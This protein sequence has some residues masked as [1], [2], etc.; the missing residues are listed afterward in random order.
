MY[1]CTFCIKWENFLSIY[2]SSQQIRIVEGKASQGFFEKHSCSYWRLGFRDDR[3]IFNDVDRSQLLSASALV[4]FCN[5]STHSSWD[6]I[7]VQCYW[8]N[9]V[10]TKGI[11]SVPFWTL[12]SPERWS[13]HLLNINLR[14]FQNDAIPQ[15]FA[16]VVRLFALSVKQPSWL[17]GNAL[18]KT[19]FPLVELTVRS[20][21]R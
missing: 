8:V 9:C 20:C 21:E 3:I 7:L 2:C 12:E 4:S 10:T 6:R 1:T 18:R 5:C 19:R 14:R 17:H 11:V 15:V 16:D 13:E